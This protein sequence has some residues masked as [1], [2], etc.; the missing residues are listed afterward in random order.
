MKCQTRLLLALA[1]PLQAHAGFWNDICQAI[2]GRPLTPP[3][4]RSR[5]ESVLRS[6]Q[7][8]WRAEFDARG[9]AF[10]DLRLVLFEGQVRTPCGL[11][12]TA[13]GPLYCPANRRLYVDR[14]FFSAA[15][16][17]LGPPTQALLIYA[18]AH[19]FGHHL[20]ALRSV[21]QTAQD[22]GQ[23]LWSGPDATEVQSRLEYQADCLAGIY[24][25][26]MASAGRLEAAALTDIRRRVGRLGDEAQAAIAARHGK[27]SEPQTAHGTSEGRRAWLDNGIS[28]PRLEA[29]ETFDFKVFQ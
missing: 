25:K 24:L 12:E 20:Q 10:E 18:M 9:W 2:L 17:Y 8:F 6:V 28:D 19:E 14:R 4:S 3:Y 23:P 15:K 13:G 7:E 22:Y 16:A 1:L 11:L 21:S 26:K 5:V 27:R 29:C